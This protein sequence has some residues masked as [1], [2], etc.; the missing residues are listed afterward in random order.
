MAEKA[1]FKKLQEEFLGDVLGVTPCPTVRRIE[2]GICGDF[3]VK[4]AIDA[5]NGWI[6]QQMIRNG[7]PIMDNHPSRLKTAH[8][9]FLAHATGRILIS[10]LGLGDSL[11]A[12]L[13]NSNVTAVRVIELEQDIIDLVAPAFA[14][15]RLVDIVQGDIYTYEPD[16]K[17]DC[18]YHALWSDAKAAKSDLAN[19]K[20]LKTRFAS[21]CSWQGFA[22]ISA[23][24]GHGINAGRKPGRTGPTKPDDV[25]RT[26][27]KGF[28]FNAKEWEALELARMLSGKKVSEIV[29]RGSIKEALRIANVDESQIEAMIDKMAS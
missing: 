3:D 20:K 11:S 24:G 28:R 22:Y 17:F 2:Q 1:G 5:D 12:V 29:V 16:T 13:G 25:K 14:K 23:R 4:D 9:E 21:Y 6:Y 10:G 8:K 27:K 26:I 15:D 19:R 7:V 18:I